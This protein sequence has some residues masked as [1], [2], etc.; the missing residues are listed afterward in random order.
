MDKF[1]KKYLDEDFIII[2]DNVIK[3]L[4]DYENNYTL[5]DSKR[6]RQLVKLLLKYLK[7]GN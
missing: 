5:Y 6:I 1:E 2:R 3:L 4:L 7:R